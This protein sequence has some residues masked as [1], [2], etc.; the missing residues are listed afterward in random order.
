MDKMCTKMGRPTSRLQTEVEAEMHTAR[1][2][3]IEYFIL[4]ALRTYKENPDGGRDQINE[5]IR[6]FP[7]AKVK[8]NKDLHKAIWKYAQAHVKGQVLAAE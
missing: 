5:Q 3:M 6:S 4:D 8:P 2:T 1:V 7:K